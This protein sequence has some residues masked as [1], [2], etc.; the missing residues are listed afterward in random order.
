MSLINA[1]KY[2]L[3]NGAARVTPEAGQIDEGNK[4]AYAHHGSFCHSVKETIII[5]KSKKGAENRER[6]ELQLVEREL[7]SK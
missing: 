4:S 7:K 2:E 3:S 6:R 1:M 5:L